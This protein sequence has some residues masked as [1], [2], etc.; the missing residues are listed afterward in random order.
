MNIIFPLRLYE[1][2]QG[3]FKTK[4]TIPIIIKVMVFIFILLPNCYSAVAIEAPTGKAAPEFSL[5][6]IDGNVISLSD[7]K[8]SIV[9]LVYLR[10][11]QTRSLTNMDE[12]QDI[13]TRYKDKGIQMIGIIAE[14]ESREAILKVITERKI[15]F[16]VLIDS[17]RNVYGNY[18]IRVYPST[19]ILDREGKFVYGI[20]GHAL[21]YK[22]RVE[23]DIRFM[24]GEITEKELAELFF[25]RAKTDKATLAAERK[26]NLAL[27]FL[28]LGLFE[29][30]IDTAKLSIE[31]K[32]DIAKSHI[33]LGFLFL[34]MQ[35]VD[36]AIEEF[37]TALQIAPD[38]HDA[39]TGLG[40]TL[41]LKG[42]T[43]SAIE[44][45]TE[46][47]LSNPYPQMTFYELGKAY[48]L[49]GEEDKSIEMF[50]NV[51]EKIVNKSIIPSSIS[52]CE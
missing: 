33:L 42:E 26:Y 52:R 45:L 37:S 35:D 32:P 3:M 8:G 34:D 38:S 48:E 50:K 18:G 12:I 5:T 7:Y 15:D 20:P 14:A 44:I 49:I 13:Y 51:I 31:A 1:G 41:I 29:Q 10:A 36:E 39:M 16:P 22:T 6:S 40:A 9:V 23:G 4:H 46:A 17:E 43:D 2:T 21:S 19:V 28:T 47:S 30:A 11:E 27:K 24:L 25:P